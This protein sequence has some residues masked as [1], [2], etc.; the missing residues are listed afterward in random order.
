MSGAVP[1]ASLARLPALDALRAVGAAAVVGTHVGFTTGATAQGVTGGFLARLDVGVA[2]FF[3]LSGFLLFRPF[4]DAAA[5]GS[6]SPNMGRYLWRRAVRILPAYWVAVVACLILLP[7]NRPATSGDWIRYTTLGQIYYPDANRHGLTQTW[8][9]AVEAVFYLLLPVLVFATVRRRWRPVRTAVVITAGGVV[10]T[11]GWLVAVSVGALDY[12]LHAA[13]LPTFAICS[14]PAWRWRSRTWPCAP[15]TARRRGGW[16]TPRRGP[17]DLLRDRARAVRCRQ[18]ADHGT[19]GPRR[20]CPRPNSVRGSF[21][22]P[23][24]PS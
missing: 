19:A 15:D 23:G 9:L 2:I 11:V 10:T 4:A 21:S 24:W 17:A 7:Q 14:P 3:V 20:R 1:S 13:W 22:S 5:V 18:H 8:S 6:K 12:T 16:S